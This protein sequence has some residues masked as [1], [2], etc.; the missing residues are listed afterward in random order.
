VRSGF[1][2]LLLYK[3]YGLGAPTP[4][5][6]HPLEA[7]QSQLMAV[8]VQGAIGGNL[9][10]TLLLTGAGIGLVCE[11]CGIS[12]LAFSIG[13]YLPITNLPMS[14]AVG[15]LACYVAKKKGGEHSEH[16]PGSLFASGLIAG[17]AL[18]GIAIAMLTVAGADQ[19][20]RLRDPEAGGA[21]FEGL[22]SSALYAGIIYMLYRYAMRK[23]PANA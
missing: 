14:M 12:A 4:A 3:A 10:W 6:P 16:D 19:A 5:H 21:L 1:I 15:A 20:L 8:L 2:L 18:M 23:K 7:P 13:L 11:L 9:P 22:L 17:D